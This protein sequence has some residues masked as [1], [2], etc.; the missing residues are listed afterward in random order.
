MGY[1]LLIREVYAIGCGT[2][3]GGAVEGYINNLSK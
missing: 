1:D 3:K 2:E